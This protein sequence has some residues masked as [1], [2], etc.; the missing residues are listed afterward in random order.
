MGAVQTA[1]YSSEYEHILQDAGYMLEYAIESGIEL[2]ESITSK[3]ISAEKESIPYW[4][5][6]D[7]GAIVSAITKIAARIHPFTA[8]TLRACREDARR[9][10][11]IYVVSVVILG[12]ISLPASIMTAV[13]NGLT[14]AINTEIDE[15]NEAAVKLHS[16]AASTNDLSKL[17]QLAISARDAFTNSLLSLGGCAAVLRV[18]NRQLES[19]T[20]NYSY[21]SPARFVIAA[22][23]GAVIGLFNFTIGQGVTA[24]PLAIAFLIGYSTDV[25]FSFL[26]GSLPNSAKGGILDRSVIPK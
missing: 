17:Q 22:I 19:R 18:F 15:G 12:A 23:G 26:E 24:P 20:F 7:A 16:G 8:E 5:G 14:S 25:F 3:I 13:Y 4:H 1:A 9:A 10:I 11:F 21:A 6:P 2:D